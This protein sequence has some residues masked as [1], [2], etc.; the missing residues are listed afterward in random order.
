MR[1]GKCILITLVTTMTLCG[2]QGTADDVKMETDTDS[3]SYA[4]GQ[5]NGSH[6]K[7]HLADYGIEEE[8]LNEVIRGLHDGTEASGDKKKRAYYFGV[9]QGLGIIENT[10]ERI[11]QKDDSK[12]LS[13]DIFM[14]GI[15]DGVSGKNK[16]PTDDIQEFVERH[17]KK[18]EREYNLKKFEQNKRQNEQFIAELKK[19]EGI[20]KLP[21]GTLYRI[22]YGGNGK[23]AEDST[24]VVYNEEVR[25]INNEIISTTFGTKNPQV[26]ELH[27][28]QPVVRE[29]IKRMKAGATWEVYVPWT[30]AEQSEES[31]KIKPF[32]AL[33]Y[34]IHVISFKT[35]K[36]SLKT[37]EP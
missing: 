20:G 19:T 22:I 28:L 32:S 15:Y 31:K 33:I 11:F 9:L 8:Y 27:N 12:Q 37:I 1:S 35:N 6:L 10:Q 13:P 29:A 17:I 14:G 7:G 26:K 2:C 4:I 23:M 3:L 30:L 21:N 16:L 34:K 36:Q 24:T 5:L 25:T 18:I